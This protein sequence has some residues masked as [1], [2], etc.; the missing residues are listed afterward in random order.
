MGG[1]GIV[2][3][4]TAA[5]SISIACV[6]HVLADEMT[7]GERVP[8]P[9]PPQ[10]AVVLNPISCNFTCSPD[11]PRKVI[12]E[13]AWPET[14]ALSQT[15]L[16]RSRLDVSAMSGGFT[17]EDFATVRLSEVPLVRETAG[18]PV[19]MQRFKAQ[20]PPALLQKVEKGRVALRDPRLPSKTELAAPQPSAPN[21]TDAAEKR[22]AIRQDDLAGSLGQVTVIAEKI[23]R[24]RAILHRVLT[25]EKLQPGLSYAF[26]VVQ[27]RDET[28]T[29]VAEEI[30]QVPVC[31][32][33]FVDSR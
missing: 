8:P 30:C 31:P 10:T 22:E 1:R 32:A 6:Q 24:K 16:E 2:A 12:A 23:E 13:V 19:D 26:R 3:F 17:S 27:Q 5:A 11:T 7:V 15:D 20:N 14:T 4:V 28:A 33:D 21:Q 9:R 18:R 29:A 25:I